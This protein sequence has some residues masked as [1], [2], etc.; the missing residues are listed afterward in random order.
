MMHSDY[1]ETMTASVRRTTIFVGGTLMALVVSLIARWS[2]DH[3]DNIID[4]VA[5]GL[6]WVAWIGCLQ[7]LYHRWQQQ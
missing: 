5:P 3:L 6:V 1:I 2:T 7:L 4:W